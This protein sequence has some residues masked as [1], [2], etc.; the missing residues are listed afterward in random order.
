[1]WRY[2]RI[3]LTVSQESCECKIHP[4][5]FFFFLIVLV[6]F[7]HL[8]VSYN[9]R[10]AGLARVSRLAYRRRRGERKS[11]PLYFR[12][13]TAANLSISYFTTPASRLGQ[14][15]SLLFSSSFFYFSHFFYSFLYTRR[16]VIRIL[17]YFPWDRGRAEKS[18]KKGERGK[19]FE[20]SF[21][22]EILC[23]ECIRGL[24]GEAVMEE[25]RILFVFS[26]TQSVLFIL[27]PIN[28]TVF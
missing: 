22:E 14:S 10:R 21:L 9:V 8:Y 3:S 23:Y 7:S 17:L 15:S 1:M 13:R 12:S 24:S 16:L 25:C 11:Y 28:Y 20:L 5:L 4:T 26:I 18:N 27:F 2:T 19:L 6:H